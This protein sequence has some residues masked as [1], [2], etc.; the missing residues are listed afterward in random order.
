MTTTRPPSRA[1]REGEGLR[2]PRVFGSVCSGIEAASV[3]WNPLGWE[4]EF[5]AEIDPFPT[6]VLAHHYPETPNLGDFTKIQRTARPISLLVG[7]TPCQS[8]SVAG[9]RGGMA[10]DR[11]N[12]ALEFLRL[13]DRLRPE[14]LVWENVPGVL[15]SWSD[16]PDCPPRDMEWTGPGDG[17]V[18][19]V[20]QRNDFGCLLSALAELG[21]G[22]SYRI[23]DA[24]Y[25]GVPQRRR[26]V[27]V[28]GR[29]GD[30]RGPAAVLFERHGLS[31][32]PPPS[33]EARTDVA[34]CLGGGS[35]S[36]GWCD[37]LDRA[38]AFIPGATPCLT[39]RPYGD[40]ESKEGL[41]VAGTLTRE[42]GEQ[43]GNGMG[44][45]A[46]GLIAHTLRGEGFDASE[47]GTGR[48]TP[49]VPVPFDTT[50]V[51]SKLNRSNPK[52]GD[53][54]H[55][56]AAGAHAPAIAYQCHGSNVGAMGTMR[57]GNGNSSGGVPFL[58]FNPQA[59]GKQTSLGYE[60]GSQTTGTLSVC[61]TPA[62]AGSAVR[63]LT[64]L[65]CERL[66]GFPDDW[67]LVPYRGKPASDGPRYKAIG[68]SIATPVLKWIGQRIDLVS[69]L[70]G[71]K[72]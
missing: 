65:E 19:A 70:M 52:P 42:Y 57:K 26:R 58:A 3:A 24:Q 14:W 55:P 67:T 7:G 6:A 12:L 5:F 45:M 37:D 40:N 16:D 18:Q 32:N 15:S 38:G 60:P 44:S 59:G 61:Q 72:K 17:R 54:C 39:G 34:G 56:L 33:R 69:E 43:S 50:Q 8:F 1:E 13:A 31:G 2:S 27:F 28:V 53:P 46:N 9:L 21:Y 20:Q 49:L 4:A 68:N 35:G 11:G 25:F 29:L 10:D 71:G 63:R 22:W 66:Q 41:L 47:D 48:G 30:W 36:R 51:T 62:I 64:P 23:L